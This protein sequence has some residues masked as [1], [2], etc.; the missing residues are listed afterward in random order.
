MTI[1]SDPIEAVHNADVVITDTHIS[2]GKE[3]EN[4]SEERLFS[5]CLQVNA[6]LVWTC[7]KGFYIYAL[8]TCEKGKRGFLVSL[9]MV[10]IQ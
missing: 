4:E 9:L 5:S 3:S 8:F 7:Q 2:I 6:E 10:P 1:T